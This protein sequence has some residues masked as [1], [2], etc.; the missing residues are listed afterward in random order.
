MENVP[1]KSNFFC[2]LNTEMTVGQIAEI[3]RPLKA[4]IR[5]CAYDDFEVCLPWPDLVIEPGPPML[6]H[7]AVAD[8]LDN[9][10]RILCLLRSAN[11]VDYSE[12]CYDASGELLSHFP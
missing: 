10:R 2:S 6:M 12:E 11:V 1:E 3:F 8:V 5:K 7:G 4:T 9:G